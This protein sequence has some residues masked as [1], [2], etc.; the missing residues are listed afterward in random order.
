MYSKYFTSKCQTLYRE[1]VRGRNFGFP[2]YL[3]SVCRTFPDRFGSRKSAT[4]APRTTTAVFGPRLPILFQPA[5]CSATLAVYS[6]STP[7]I[8]AS[9]LALQE[10]YEEVHA[11][12]TIVSIVAVSGGF[13]SASF[14]PCLGTRRSRYVLMMGKSKRCRSCWTNK[15]WIW[16]LLESGPD[17]PAKRDRSV[18]RIQ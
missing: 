7:Q 10:C 12:S 9:V 8:P 14:G 1:H 18:K 15:W 2:L 6:G 5:L 13:V 16:R 3:S 4:M 17:P 11:D